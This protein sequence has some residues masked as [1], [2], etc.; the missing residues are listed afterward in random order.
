MHI[1]EGKIPAPGAIAWGAACSSSTSPVTPVRSAR[2]SWFTFVLSALKLGGS[3]SHP[4]GS[5]ILFRPPVMAVLGTITLARCC[6]H[7]AG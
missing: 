7:T 1:A 5:A 2:P 6:W 4:T 3:C